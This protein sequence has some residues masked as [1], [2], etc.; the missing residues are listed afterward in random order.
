MYD[1][2]IIVISEHCYQTR[3]VFIRH[4]LAN[5]NQ[6]ATSMIVSPAQHMVGDTRALIH[7]CPY[8]MAIVFL[9]CRGHLVNHGDDDASVMAS[10]GLYFTDRRACAAW[11]VMSHEQN[12]VNGGQYSLILRRLTRPP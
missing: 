7:Y 2:Q 6:F 11:R 3:V 8:N 1:N 5:T 12:S 4:R 9:A 10:A